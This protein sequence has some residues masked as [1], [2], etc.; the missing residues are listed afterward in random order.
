MIPA[1]YVLMSHKTEQSYCRVIAELKEAAFTLNLVLNPEIILSDIELAE[2]QA[3]KFHFP[4][5]KMLGC[6]FH[7]GQCL[8]KKLV[9]V[10]LKHEY[11]NFITSCH[12]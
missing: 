8:F 7:F 4:N 11:S 6:F 10:G 2:I 12:F 1:C 5:F 9:E 3:F